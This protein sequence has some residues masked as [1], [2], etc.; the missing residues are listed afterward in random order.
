M[1]EKSGKTFGSKLKQM[2]KSKSKDGG[3]DVKKT[4]IKHVTSDSAIIPQGSSS[5]VMHL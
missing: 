4:K 1:K 2:Y 5:I 3:K